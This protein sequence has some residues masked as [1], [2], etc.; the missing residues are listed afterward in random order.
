MEG[1]LAII[2]LGSG[3]YFARRSGT[4]YS[5]Y[6]N[7]FN[8]FYFA[9]REVLGGRDPYQNRLGPW[10]PY[11]Y[12]PVLAELLA[13]IA[14]LPVPLAAYI[15]FVA[16]GVSML[17]AAR[18]AS[19]LSVQASGSNST[20]ES[21]PE[22]KP[23]M[24]AET[25]VALIASMVVGR[26]ALD[27]FAMGQV[28][29]IVT[30]LAVAHL[31]LYAKDRRR[32]SALA[33]ALAASLKLTPAVLIIYHLARGRIRF[34]AGTS[35][36]LVCLLAGGFLVFGRGAIVAV[37][38]FQQ[39]TIANGQGFDL[40]Y[41]GNQSIR[42]AELRLTSE[43]DDG[44][45]KPYDWASLAVSLVLLLGAVFAARRQA[46]EVAAAPLFCCMVMLSP[47]AWKAHFVALILPAACLAARAI[48]RTPGV[49]T[50][51]ARFAIALTF[52]LFTLTSPTLIGATGAEWTDYHSLVL[53]GT[54]VTYL[55]VLF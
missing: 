14:L 1:L 39:Q 45:R 32:L 25:L 36:L 35:L 11:L 51:V 27:C 49:K 55:A 28:N 21:T 47:L 13:P 50:S 5:A 44:R 8:V 2:L 34:A 9:A 3:L 12:P 38:A 10:T 31:Y 17:L 26:F 41:S 33:L 42:G 22:N 20:G 18:M 30:G 53:F 48:R 54:L 52:V 40:G 7:D 46:S 43:S 37:R 29:A 16:S 24:A 4:D 23:T 15:W 6:G 19:V